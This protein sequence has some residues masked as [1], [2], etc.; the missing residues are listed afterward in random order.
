MIFY[1]YRH[2][3]GHPTGHPLV[4]LFD[5]IKRDD[6]IKTGQK[7]KIIKRLKARDLVPEK[8]MARK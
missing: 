6:V 5:T 4:T 1:K 7:P 3:S 2:G 8:M